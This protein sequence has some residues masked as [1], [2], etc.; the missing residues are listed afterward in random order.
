MPLPSPLPTPDD[1]LDICLI[2]SFLYHYAVTFC[3]C[4]E[5]LYLELSTFK[6]NKSKSPSSLPTHHD[7]GGTAKIFSHFFYWG[8][9]IAIGDC[10]NVH[11]AV[12]G[13]DMPVD[14]DKNRRG[15]RAVK[16]HKGTTSVPESLDYDLY[17]D[18][19]VP[20]HGGDSDE[21]GDDEE[22]ELQVMVRE[23]QFLRLEGSHREA[24]VMEREI[25]RRRQEH[26]NRVKKRLERIILDILGF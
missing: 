24:A 6:K 5:E 19:G 15:T 12:V 20:L 3:Q 4:C 8:M 21:E 10:R 16:P 11:P 14:V 18:V 25:Q 26:I 13:G 23:M 2:Y 22:D 17:D 1:F 7:D 9:M